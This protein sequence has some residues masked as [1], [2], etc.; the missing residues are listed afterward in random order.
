MCPGIYLLF[1]FAKSTDQEYNGQLSFTEIVYAVCGVLLYVSGTIILAPVIIKAS[2]DWVLDCFAFRIRMTEPPVQ[3]YDTART[4]IENDE[5]DKAKNLLFTL[6]E[7][8]P[9]AI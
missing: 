1:E 8:Y 2:L 3:I 5:Y 6:I 4:A 7:R 9:K